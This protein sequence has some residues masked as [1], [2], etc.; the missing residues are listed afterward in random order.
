MYRLV[1]EYANIMFE[2]SIISINL[3]RIINFS[4]A[5]W[6]KGEPQNLLKLLNIL[7]QRFKAAFSVH[8]ISDIAR[9]DMIQFYRT[10]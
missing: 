2:D 3:I 10:F 1:F 7:C 8:N 9:G 5:S 4:K 6:F